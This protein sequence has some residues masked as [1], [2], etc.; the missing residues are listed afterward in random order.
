M[1]AAEI[2]AF[3]THLA[4]AGRVRAST[5]NQAFSAILFLYLKV[6]EVDP[7]R[8]AGVVRAKRPKRL[9]VVLTPDEVRRTLAAMEGTCRLIALLLYGAG[10]RLIESLRLRVQDL[11]WDRG[12]IL[13]RHGK[14]GKD[15]RTMLPA[16]AAGDAGGPPGAGARVAP[17]QPGPRLG[18]GGAAVC[19]GAK[20]SVGGDGL[21]LAIC[22]PVGDYWA[23]PRSGTSSHH[24]HPAPVTRAIGEAGRRASLGKRATSHSLRHSFATH[25]IESG[26]DIRTVQELL[27]HVDVSTTMI[28]THVLNKN[29]RGSAAR[30]TGWPKG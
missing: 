8:I 27:G 2:N 7:G 23:D 21:A 18:P 19:D 24:A 6:L 3:L 20:E 5:Q 26:Y 16:S 17:A 10:L 25:L 14:G 15:R 1:G 22:L 9:P 28:Y 13:V 29:G 11:D 30:W 12:E 4:V